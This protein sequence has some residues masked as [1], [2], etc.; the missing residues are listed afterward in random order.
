MKFRPSHLVFLACGSAALLNQS[1]LAIVTEYYWDS[2]GSGTGGSDS[3]TANG[4][5]GSSAYWSADSTGASST[6]NTVMSSSYG[7]HFSAG[8]NVTGDSTV[9]LNAN[10]SVGSI[11]FD[12][13]T[14]T[15]S[16]YTLTLGSS[17]TG[18]GNGIINSVLAGSSRL[19]KTG[20][21]TVKLTGANTFTGEIV[22]NGGVLNIQ[23]SAALGT[24]AGGVSSSANNA[25]LQLQGGISI[26]AEALTLRGTGQS[27]TI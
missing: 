11:Y 21:G 20:T 3:T 5:W 25:E 7:V 6:A 26:G 10:K 17:L 24:T 16:G 13:G 9:T 14:V 22:I 15:L 1:A 19:S 18:S 27:N 12:E 23:N 8:T 4:T 2:N